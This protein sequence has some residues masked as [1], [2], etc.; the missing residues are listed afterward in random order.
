[1]SGDKDKGNLRTGEF[2]TKKEPVNPFEETGKVL[3]HNFEP[4]AS[5][6]LPTAITFRG[7]KTQNLQ[8]FEIGF[9]NSLKTLSEPLRMSGDE[10]YQ[11]IGI[12]REWITA[13]QDF[14]IKFQQKSIKDQRIFARIYRYR[15]ILSEFYVEFSGKIIYA[16]DLKELLKS[17]LKAK[18]NKEA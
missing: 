2:G 18:E 1:M 13:F 11:F 16:D 15:V 3:E 6:E 4:A 17:L 8:D 10:I 5:E 12:V 9:L 7:E 14:E